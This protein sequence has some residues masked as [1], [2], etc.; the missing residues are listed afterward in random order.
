MAP[1]QEVAIFDGTVAQNVALTWGSDIDENRVR[2]ALQRAQ[3]LETI[4]SRKDGIHGRVGERGLALSGGQ[5]QRL[6]IARALYMDPLVLVLDEAT[7]AW[8]PPPKPP[9]PRPSANSTAR[10]LSSR[11]P[12]ASPRSATTIRSAS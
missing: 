2:T 3:L 7:S 12:T 10:S 6:G 5:R 4:E 8:T 1:P 11:S 9:S